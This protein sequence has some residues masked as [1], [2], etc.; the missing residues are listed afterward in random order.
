MRAELGRIE[1]ILDGE[2]IALDPE[3]RQSFRDLMASRGNLHY[4]AFD[5][6]WLERE[7]APFVVVPDAAC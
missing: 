5:V 4:A 3:G 1:A 7:G 6:L 2:V